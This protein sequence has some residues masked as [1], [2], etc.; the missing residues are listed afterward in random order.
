MAYAIMRTEKLKTFGNI[1]GVGSHHFRTRETKNADS[2]KTLDNIR[3][4]ECK[5][6]DLVEAVKK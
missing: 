2:E 6:D 4:I 5:N 1:G 3:L